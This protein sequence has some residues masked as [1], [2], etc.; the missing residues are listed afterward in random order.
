MS[1]LDDDGLD[2]LLRARAPH[3]AIGEPEL[4]PGDLQAWRSGRLDA[5]QAAAVDAV[6]ARSAAD[7]AMLADLA[8]PVD[9]GLLDRM[10]VATPR[11]Q[12]NRRLVWAGAGL[13]LAAGLTFAVLRPGAP[14]APAYTLGAVRGAVKITRSQTPTQGSGEPAVFVPDGTLRLTVRPTDAGRTAAAA[15]AFA[16]CDD[17][18]FRAVDG[19][20]AGA[21]GAWTL[22]ASARSLFGEAPGRCVVAIAL[23]AD[24]DA[25]A[26]LDGMDPATAAEDGGVQLVPL[27]VDYRATPDGETP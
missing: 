15:R 4:D 17:G 21:D 25:L 12:S 18:A 13:A 14:D 24:A 3:P 8:A 7:R 20:E 5:E 23:A 16:A 6:L 26:D 9:A 11:P 1:A 27:T 10:A 2:A 22:V 19:L